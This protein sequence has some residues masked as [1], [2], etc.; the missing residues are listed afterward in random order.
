MTRLRI[1]LGISAIAAALTMGANPSQSQVYYII[2]GYPASVSDTQYLAAQ[3]V[4]PGRYLFQNGRLFPAGSGPTQSRPWSHS[5]GDGFSTGSDGK[6]CF[7]AGDWS[8]C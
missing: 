1:L 8:N 2:N 4:P 3:G 5:D 6:G 7:Y